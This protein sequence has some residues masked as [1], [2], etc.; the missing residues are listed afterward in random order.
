M[1]FLIKFNMFIAETKLS[2]EQNGDFNPNFDIST[3]L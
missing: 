1:L 2:Y 3:K